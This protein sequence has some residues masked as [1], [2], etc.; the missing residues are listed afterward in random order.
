[1]NCSARPQPLYTYQSQQGAI[2]SLRLNH[3]HYIEM[4][5]ICAIWYYTVIFSSA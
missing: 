2:Q 4:S 5:D 3:C 1:M